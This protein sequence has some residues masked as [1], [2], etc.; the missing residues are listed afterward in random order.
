MATVGGPCFARQKVLFKN[1]MARRPR[2]GYAT[3]MRL[4]PRP[5]LSWTDEGLPVDTGVDDIYFS[6]DDGLAESRIV[7]LASSDLPTRWLTHTHF[8]I[9]ELGFGTGLNFLAAWELWTAQGPPR[10]WLNFVSFEGYPLDQEDVAQALGAWPELTDI[11][12]KLV[13]K[14][15]DRAAGVHHVSWPEDRISLT[16]HIGDVAATLPKAELKADAWFLDG[17]SPSKNPEMW[18][19]SLWPLLAERSAAGA[20][21]ATFTVAGGVRRGLQSAG[22]DVAKHPGHG[23]KR[24]RLSGQLRASENREEQGPKPRAIGVKPDAKPSQI[25]VL[26]GGIGGSF[27]AHRL[28]ARG[29]R[30]TL[31]DPAADPLIGASG[32]PAAL[33]MP[34]LDAGDT[35]VARLMV[36]AYVRALA[37]YRDLPGSSE[38]DVVHRPSGEKEIERFAKMLEDPPLGLERLEA[39]SNGGALHK[40]ARLIRPH[41]LIEPLLSGVE[42]K[43]G[44]LPDIDLKTRTINGERFRAI[45]LASGMAVAD[46]APWLRLVGR[47]GQVDYYQSGVDAPASAIASGHYALADGELRLWGASFEAAKGPAEI[48]NAARE[49]NAKALSELNPYWQAEARNIEPQSRAGIRATT[50]DRLP[51][52]G[53]LPDAEVVMKTHAGLRTGQAVTEAVALQPGVFVV[54]GFGSRGFTWAPWAADLVTAQLFGDPLPTSSE[55]VA[56][57]A[58]ERQLLRDLKRGRI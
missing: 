18:Q 4:P 29:A 58:P 23:R 22:F 2:T 48:S 54:T 55:S 10:G 6:R 9:A 7:F 38:V 16:L 34:R 50:P 45:V 13:S 42:T 35:P 31:F 30:V 36:E 47:M 46:I 51:V 20:S 15:P 43:F 53:P 3:V 44:S 11:A 12:E 8:T 49:A 14:W 26:G 56:L 57:V 39:I 17:F 5:K 27:L 1:G 33:V 52:I 21:V 25:A 28:A 41:D 37:A 24:E 32:N 19:E 40:G